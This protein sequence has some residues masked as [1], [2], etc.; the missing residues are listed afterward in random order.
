[1]SGKCFDTDSLGLSYFAVAK[2]KTLRDVYRNGRFCHFVFDAEVA[3]LA[4][5]YHNNAPVPVLSLLSAIREV[6]GRMKSA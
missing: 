1:M 5:E 6:R 2:G 3:G 4:Q